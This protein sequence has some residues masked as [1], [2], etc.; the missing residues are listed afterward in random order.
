MTPLQ[1][2][3][4]TAALLFYTISKLKPLSA[5]LAYIREKMPEKVDEIRTVEQSIQTLLEGAEL[6]PTVA[7]SYTPEADSRKRKSP[8]VRLTGVPIQRPRIE[9]EAIPSDHGE[10][11]M[12]PIEDEPLAIPTGL[13]G[14]KGNTDAKQ[15]GLA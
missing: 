9:V 14:R 5:D 7:S 15:F 2:R 6:G 11:E 4:A 3:R 1:Q 13:N 10:V 12:L 8:P